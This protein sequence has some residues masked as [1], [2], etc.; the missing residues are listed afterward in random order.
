M[1]TIV[2]KDVF[3][4]V[5]QKI[6]ED[7]EWCLNLKCPLNKAEV[8]HF[9]KYGIKNKKELQTTHNLFE[10]IKRDLKLENKE[11]NVQVHFKKPPVYLCTRRR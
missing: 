10:N 9:R 1:R 11:L 7:A 6:C 5:K 3:I 8:K 2:V 4:N